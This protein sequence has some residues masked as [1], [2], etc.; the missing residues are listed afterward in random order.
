MANEK[1]FLI[2]D[3]AKELGVKDATARG[4]LRQAGIEKD[5][6]QYEWSKTAFDKVVRQLK[7]EK[8][9]GG[10]K[11]GS[12]D[13]ASAKVKGKSVAKKSKASKEDLDEAA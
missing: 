12:G 13:K 11:G 6:K 8:K 10:D 1:T 5:G 9:S 4:L 3:L 2:G 7:A